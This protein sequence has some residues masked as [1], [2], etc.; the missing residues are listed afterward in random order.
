MVLATDFSAYLSASLDFGIVLFIYVLLTLI[1]PL[2]YHVIFKH[3]RT[4][5]FD[6]RNYFLSGALVVINIVSIVYFHFEKDI[7]NDIYEI[8]DNLMTY[9]N[10][11]TAFFIFPTFICYYSHTSYKLIGINPFG[12][13]WKESHVK[14]G[15]FLFVALFNIYI[16]YW[17]LNTYIINSP[18]LKSTFEVVSI[19]YLVFS[20]YLLLNL[21]KEKSSVKDQ[22]KDHDLGFDVELL[23]DTIVSALEEE[24]LF[25]DAKRNVRL[26]ARAVNSNVKYVSYVINKVHNKNF[27]NFINDYRI[28]HA[29]HLLLDNAHKKMTI[30]AIGNLSG[31]NSKSS[32]NT[33]FKKSTGQTPS[34]FMKDDI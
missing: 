32:F 30:E 1:P 2:L 33:T 26:L 5:V 34:Q 3:L 28:N 13:S 20:F 27:A 7:D 17:V 10:Y 19:L 12:V 14:R 21:S 31:F 15:L 23:N 4:G 24:Q 25:L 29:K 6:K 8:V 16:I 9:I 22:I 18:L 11:V